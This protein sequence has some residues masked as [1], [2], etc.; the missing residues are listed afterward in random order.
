M[1]G[2]IY[3]FS[4]H[5]EYNEFIKVYLYKLQNDLTYKFSFKSMNY[6]INSFLI[7]ENY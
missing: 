5:F 6:T 2:Y 4:S 7:F 1:L 3:V